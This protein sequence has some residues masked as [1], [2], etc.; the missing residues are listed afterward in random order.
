[1]H[2]AL[3][4]TSVNHIKLE[5]KMSEDVSCWL[6]S[7]KAYCLGI[8]SCACER[9]SNSII[10]SNNKMRYSFAGVRRTPRCQFGNCSALLRQKKKKWKNEIQVANKLTPPTSQQDWFHVA[11]EGWQ[12]K[13]DAKWSLKRM[14]KS[15]RPKPELNALESYSTRRSTHLTHRSQVKSFPPKLDD[16]IATKTYKS[17]ESILSFKLL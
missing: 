7:T 17:F 2:F 1:M 8:L 4:L 16:C 14:Q 6:A 13:T 12:C 15:A 5:N 10:N 9:H 3:C 11:N